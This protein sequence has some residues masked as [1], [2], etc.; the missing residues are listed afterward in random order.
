M[1]KRNMEARYKGSVLGLFWSF[2]HP[3]IMLSVYTFVFS[4]LMGAKWGIE[5]TDWGLH[6]A[7]SKTA[8]AIV[9]LCGLSIF[10]L[11]SE[12]TLCSST[13]VVS[14]PNLIKKVIFPLE[15]LP[16]SQV[17]SVFMLGLAWV[18]I[19]FVGV[20]LFFGK[21]SLFMLLLP[22]I[23]FPLFMIALGV[24]YFVSSLGVYL[25]DTQYII[26]VIMQLLFWG[27]PIVYPIKLL[28]DKIGDVS[29]DVIMAASKVIEYNPLTIL[30]EQARKVFVFGQNPD[31]IHLLIV[32]FVSGLVLQLGYFWFIRTRKG[33]SDVV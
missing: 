28:K 29:C 30:I 20:V 1:T 26:N 4:W 16:L 18:V 5:G 2:V 33:F 9:M 6:I 13:V 12:S 27:V 11:F 10:N 14:N 23:L 32:Y 31:W 21:L 8:F 15:I 22:L 19:L 24:S 17:L 25:R 3:L 7:E